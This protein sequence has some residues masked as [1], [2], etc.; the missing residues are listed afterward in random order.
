MF[1]KKDMGEI[2]STNNPK[3]LSKTIIKVLNRR[4]NPEIIRKGAM[5]ADTRNVVKKY[6]N[7]YQRIIK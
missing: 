5:K 1:I 6:N 4:Y 3:E 2:I 7:L